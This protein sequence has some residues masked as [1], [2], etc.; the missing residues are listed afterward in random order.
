MQDEGK[1]ERKGAIQEGRA[2]SGR[3]ERGWQVFCRGK[4]STAGKVTEVWTCRKGQE[5]NEHHAGSRKL[6]FCLENDRINFLLK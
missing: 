2:L 4:V 3:R 6:N 5:Q 1:E